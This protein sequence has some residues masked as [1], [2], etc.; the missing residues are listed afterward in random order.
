MQTGRAAALQGELAQ[1]LSTNAATE[2]AVPALLYAEDL[3]LGHRLDVFDASIARWRSTSARIEAVAAQR[4][5]GVLDPHVGEGFGQLSLAGALT[6]PGAAPDPD[7]ELYVHEAVLTW[8]GWSLTAPR[9]GA[10]LSRD[11]RAPDPDVPESQPVRVVNDP[12]T[13]MGLSFAAS[14]TPGTL[15]RLRFGRSYRIRLRSVD[16]AGNGTTMADADRWLASPA[17]ATPALPAR[18]SS[19]Y[20]RFEPVPAPA[21]VPAT[22]YG[23]GASLLRLVIRS[24]GEGAAAWVEAF[25]A[26]HGE[27]APEPHAPYDEHD[28]RHLAPPKASFELAERHA[29][30]DLVMGADGVP[31]Q[32]RR[33]EIA[34][35][36]EVARREKGSFDDPDAPGAEV[37]VIEAR[38]P[39]VGEPPAEA[40]PQR[41]VIYR[42]PQLEL[43]YLPDPLAVGTVLF[44]LPGRVEPEPLRLGF[45]GA[46]WYQRRPL[47]LRLADGDGAPSWDADGRVLTVSLPAATRATIRVASQLDAIDQMALLAWCEQEL[48]GE[49]LDRVVM[50]ISENRSWLTTPWHTVDLVH[51]VQHP[52]EVPRWADLQ[53]SRPQG[54]TYVDVAG[55]ADVDGR[56][57]QRVD[58]D[59]AW[60]EPV[61]DPREDGPRSCPRARPCSACRWTSR[62]WSRTTAP[63]PTGCATAA[64]PPSTP[65]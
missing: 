9:P 5:A 18:T 56:S 7:G 41:Y 48:T 21:V 3:V 2:N 37:V 35:A 27:G 51:A 52:L 63:P 46:A 44:G 45:D 22:A 38:P 33:D 16:L 10:S 24:N 29:M 58:L 55:V 26:E 31:D 4:Y 57:T 23:E 19:P 50:A 61:D 47:R 11:P 20:L 54:A 65:G 30:F 14:V 39:T 17:A 40:A 53:V 59:A 43:P 34:A 36:Y 28:E 6:P 64:S 13:S 42:T 60:T 15:P 49:K 62:P 1:G 12:H 32:A 8:D 25:N